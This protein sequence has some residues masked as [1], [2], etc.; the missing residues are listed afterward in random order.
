MLALFKSCDMGNVS[1]HSKTELSKS[2]NQSFHTSCD[3]SKNMIS[4]SIIC[5]F[6]NLLISGI[7]IILIRV[8]ISSFLKKEFTKKSQIK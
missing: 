2:C 8:L 5:F 7:C 1:R 6:M 4:H 3:N